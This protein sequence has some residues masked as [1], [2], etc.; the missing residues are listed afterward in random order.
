[1]SQPSYEGGTLITLAL[2]M[3][4]LGQLRVKSFAHDHTAGGRSPHKNV[5]DMTPEGSYPA[6]ACAVTVST[7]LLRSVWR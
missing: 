1:M 3:K 2:Q 4:K 5:G 6:V 7:L